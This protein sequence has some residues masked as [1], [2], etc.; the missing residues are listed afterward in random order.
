MKRTVVTAL[1]VLVMAAAW[2]QLTP[3]LI[4]KL[5]NSAGQYLP[6]IVAMKERFDVAD[7][8]KSFDL[9]GDD[10]A[11][12]AQAIVILKNK[13][14]ASHLWLNKLVAK[15]GDQAKEFK[16]FWITNMVAVKATPVVIRE[17][18]AQP[19]VQAI[20]LDEEQNF[21]DYK[22]G[23]AQRDAW[24]LGKI[25]SKTVNEK[26]RGKG[27][28]V[29]VIDTGV[30]YNHND[31]KGRVLK[32]KDCYSNDMDPIDDNGHGS[33]CAGSI[34]GTTYG[35]AP[36]VTILAVKVLSGGGSGSW[37][38]V[39]DGVQYV[40]DYN[41]NGKR[42]DIA[43]MS[44][45]G[46]PPIQAVLKTAFD[47]ALKLGVRFAI[48]AGNSGPNAK[49]IGTPG[50]IKEV[51]TVGATDIN[52]AIA[53]FSS[54]GPVDANGTSYI[55][56]D[57][58]AP[59]VNITSCWKDGADASN[60]ISGT[61]MATPHVAG[62]MALVLEAKPGLTLAEIKKVLE[63][64]ALDLG[65]AGRD[66]VFGSG[67]V[68]AVEAVQ[69]VAMDLS[70]IEI[71]KEIDFPIAADGTINTTLSI[72]NPMWQMKVKAEV[73]ILN[74][75]GTYDV[76]FTFRKAGKPDQTGE[77]KGLASNKP[78]LLPQVFIA[79][80]DT[81]QVILVG[82]YTGSSTATQGKARVKVKTV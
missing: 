42:V 27:I 43:S 17:I 72:D 47:N 82:K 5:D 18:A 61:S 40:A 30:N 39:A 24:G 56:P 81:N 48:A 19:D 13:A 79:Y 71:T 23:V 15:H 74:P 21:I 68:R 80:S 12:K 4:Q 16:S 25:G 53:S 50:D 49:T 66:N 51:V 59:G 63:D 8:V 9:K 32:G 44:L 55:K 22:P 65:A 70:R 73:T 75:D 77:V 67:R 69:T 7:I 46:R 29:A 60:T 14:E 28:L 35:V 45:G 57:I 41:V 2:A 26:Y 54:R 38:N 10:E 6:V 3:E 1:L 52:D 64:T 37:Q 34:G 33:H 20:F 76:A 58:S 11:V 36:E 62:L 31:L 78:Y